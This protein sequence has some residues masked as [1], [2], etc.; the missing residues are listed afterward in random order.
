[1]VH[2]TPGTFGFWTAVAIASA[3]CAKDPDLPAVRYALKVFREQQ[4]PSNFAKERW[5]ASYNPARKVT[6]VS[7]FLDTVSYYLDRLDFTSLVSPPVEPEPP[8]FIPEQPRAP[9]DPSP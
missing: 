3:R 7:W 2:R 4:A 6:Y 9:I 5:A 1:M 8:V